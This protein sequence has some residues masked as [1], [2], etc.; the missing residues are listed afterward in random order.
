M[1]SINGRHAKRGPDALG[2]SGRCAAAMT[3]FLV[4]LVAMTNSEATPNYAIDCFRSLFSCI[5]DGTAW[6]RA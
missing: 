5:C 3:L 1:Q 4:N 2:T 6:S